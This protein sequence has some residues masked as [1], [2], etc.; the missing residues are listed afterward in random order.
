ML[1]V[2]QKLVNSAKEWGKDMG[3]FGVK[4]FNV[5]KCP[6][7]QK[8]LQGANQMAHSIG[9]VKKKKKKKTVCASLFTN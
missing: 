2:P 3:V 4:G 9:G 6:M 7:F 1:P 5:G 8:Y